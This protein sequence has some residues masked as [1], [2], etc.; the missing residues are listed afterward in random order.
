MKYL[1]KSFALLFVCMTCSGNVLAFNKAEIEA[2][3]NILIWDTGA[4]AG[5]A[6][7][8][9]N[10]TD[11]NRPT[12]GMTELNLNAK[13][14]RNPIRIQSDSEKTFQSLGLTFKDI[15]TNPVDLYGS[16][17]KIFFIL[18][19]EIHL[20]VNSPDKV[21]LLHE[22]FAID[23]FNTVEKLR[24][25]GISIL[26]SIEGP[27][28]LSFITKINL[29]PKTPEGRKELA[30]QIRNKNW[31]SASQHIGETQSD[32]VMN[33]Y[34]DDNRLTLMF[35]L[36]LVLENFSN[37]SPEE[38]IA[39][40]KD[41]KTNVINL[42][43]TRASQYNI[44]MLYDFYIQSAKLTV[45]QTKELSSQLCEDRSREMA[46]FTLETARNQRKK[47]VFMSFGAF[48]TYGVTNYLKSQNIGYMV[49]SPN[50]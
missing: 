39:A 15:K 16:V 46:K 33:I 9:D 21:K 30:E 49:L 26:N 18:L 13:N 43:P 25:Q 28:G 7:S 12:S 23:M 14:N 10:F 20:G 27:R 34:S 47:I 19:P 17:G 48:H 31:T 1:D 6:D 32:M 2:T 44:D 29:K 37:K 5:K 11:L 50:F 45:E 38:K 22:S 4:E 40:W 3:S 24:E 8:Q 35:G 41:A 42:F 36:S